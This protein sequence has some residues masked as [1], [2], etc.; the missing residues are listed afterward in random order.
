VTFR[1]NCIAAG[2]LR[3]ISQVVQNA[4]GVMADED[5]T[6][7]RLEIGPFHDGVRFANGAQVTATAWS[8]ARRATSS[9]H[10]C[11][12]S[13]RQRWQRYFDIGYLMHTHRNLVA[14]EFRR[15]FFL[16]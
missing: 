10:S 1:W 5:V 16:P 12:P 9:T 15:R 14:A 2:R 13:G 3:E 8:G 4:C 6:F 11:R 7:T